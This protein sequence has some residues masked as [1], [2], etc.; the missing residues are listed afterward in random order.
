M[1]GHVLKNPAASGTHYDIGVDSL[2]YAAIPAGVTDSGYL[3]GF[4]AN[5]LR[6]TAHSDAGA[7]TNLYG[8]SIAYGHYV[9]SGHTP[10]A[11]R[12]I[13]NAYGL[14]ITPY[15]MDGTITNSYGLYIGSPVT[16]G[17][18]GNQYGIYQQST[19]VPNYFAGNVGI[20]TTSS[21]SRLHVA[22]GVQ[23]GNDTADC[24]GASNVKLGAMRYSAGA[25]SVCVAAGWTPLATGSGALAA[26]STGQVQFNG[27]SGTFAADAGLHW[28]NTNKRLGIGTATPFDRFHVKDGTDK[29]LR[30]S[31]YDF[32]AGAGVSFNSANDADSAHMPMSFAAS[33]FH[34]HYGDVGIGTATPG[35]KL[36][37]AGA[38]QTSAGIDPAADLGGIILPQQGGYMAW[39]ETIGTGMTSF[40]N[41]RGMGAGG[42]DFSMFDGSGGFVSTPLTIRGDGNVGIGI[43]APRSRLQIGNAVSETDTAN[44][45]RL[46]D[47]GETSGDVY[48]LGIS[49]QDFDFFSQN[50]YRFHVGSLND[51]RGT[52]AFTILANGRVGIGMAAPSAPLHIGLTAPSG[53]GLRIS[54]TSE[55]EGGQLTLMDATGAGGWEIDNV[56]TGPSANLRFFRDKGVS[57]VSIAMAIQPGG[58]VGIGTDAP[59][60]LLHVEGVA[61]SAQA[62]FATSSDRRVKENIHS[63][64]GGLEA[65]AHL[66]PVTFTYT[67]EYQAGN[68]ALAG[69]KRGFIAQEM[70]TVLPDAVTRAPEVVGSRTIEDFR[71]LGNSDFVP[72]LVSAVK[73]LKADNENLRAEMQAQIDDQTLRI[74]ELRGELETL[75]AAAGR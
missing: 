44:M 58:N 13:T 18:V 40:M 54:N 23:M 73:E 5:A 31:G 11:S 72:L 39:N 47:G 69:T 17:T 27:G 53:E 46:Y 37:V 4:R 22:G 70:E 57:N 14:R 28:D 56:G 32:G 12:T 55:L 24:P 65:V 63:I 41:H 30:V 10:V 2:V 8:N 62:N 33:S 66:N 75:K 74:R 68:A 34:F 3:T 71:V 67:H 9:Y 43:A 61:R 35:A 25:F 52:E 16:G 1:R 49:A 48:G 38:L 19:T 7:L 42:F 45:I 6:T 26:G 51:N 59:S 64:N 20:G 50:T 21:A 60:H 29:N 36:G 15:H